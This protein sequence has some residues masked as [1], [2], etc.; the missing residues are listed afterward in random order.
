[1][2][3]HRVSV[4]NGKYTFVKSDNDYRV[5]ILRYSEPWY[6]PQSEASNAL[7]SIMRELD[8]ARIV[9]EVARKLCEKQS[10]GTGEL[11]DAIRKHD[12]LTD[13]CTPPSEWTK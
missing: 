2:S 13:D 7:H 12:R 3:D 9:L 10:F 11:K 5:S 8:A 6:G 1:M 4:D